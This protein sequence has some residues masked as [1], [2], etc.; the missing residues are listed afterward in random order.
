MEEE[1]L[2]F[3]IR[4]DKSPKEP[5]I[6]MAK[7]FMENTDFEVHA[8]GE[9]ANNQAVKAIA[10]AL[11]TLASKGIYAGVDIFFGDTPHNKKDGIMSTVMCYR[12]F[13]KK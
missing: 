7:T 4:A 9:V 3:R 5:A 12:I 2:I 6:A 1:K 10:I 8:I 11:S 13:K